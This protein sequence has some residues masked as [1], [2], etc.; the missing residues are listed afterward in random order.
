MQ[1]NIPWDEVSALF[2]KAQSFSIATVDPDG[3][4][5]V[6]PIGSVLLTGEGKGY[7]FEKF[8]QRLRRNLDRDPRMS[9]MV[10]NP[11]LAFWV[12]SLWRGRFKTQPA[13]RLACEAGARRKGTQEECDAWLSKVRLFRYFKGHDL[14]WKDMSFLREFSVIRVE[15]VELGE[16][17]P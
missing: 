1:S 9:I 7:Y 14:L 6:S 13:V 12:A 17:N 8:P 10:V 16:M 3:A 4:P 15:P 11:G 2:N 5:R